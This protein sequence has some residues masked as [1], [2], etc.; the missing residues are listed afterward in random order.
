MRLCIKVDPVFEQSQ[1]ILSYTDTFTKSNEEIPQQ[2]KAI[3]SE[4]ELIEFFNSDYGYAHLQ[5]DINL[6]REYGGFSLGAGKVLDGRGHSITLIDEYA[7]ATVYEV[8]AGEYYFYSPEEATD[9]DRYGLFVNVNDGEIKNIKFIFSSSVSLVNDG[10][11]RE[12]A[13]SIVCGENNGLIHNCDLQ[14][15]GSFEYY[16]LS[17]DYEGSE[18]FK[19]DYGGFAG[20]NN[21]S[22]TNVG[23]KYE[24]FYLRLFTFAQ[25]GSMIG[26]MFIPAQTLAGGIIGE[27]TETANCENIKIQGRGVSYKLSG[28]G[29]DI[30]DSKTYAGAVAAIGQVDNVIVDFDVEYL[31][32][33]TGTEVISKNAVVH[34]GRAVNVTALNLYGGEENLRSNNMSSQ[35]DIEYCNYID[36]DNNVR[37]RV[38]LN[39]NNDQIIEVMPQRGTSGEMSF[40]KYKEENGKIA[41]DFEEYVNVPQNFMSQVI[42]GD[43]GMRVAA[44]QTDGKDYWE[45][46]VEETQEIQQPPA[47]EVKAFEE[48][49]EYISGDVASGEVSFVA[50]AIGGVVEYRIDGGE[51]IAY[52]GDII[53]VE[54]SQ[55]EFRAVSY[56][57]SLVSDIIVY[58][59]I[60]K[61]APMIV[62]EQWFNIVANK[63]YDGTDSV[64]SV[65]LNIEFFDTFQNFMLIKNNLGFSARYAQV[66]VGAVDII[67]DLW[68]KDSSKFEIAN[69]SLI[70]AGTITPKEVLVTLEKSYASYGLTEW[71]FN[72]T[73]ENLIGDDEIDLKFVTDANKYSTPSDSYRY[74]LAE[75]DYG[76]Y[77]VDNFA[78]L[79]SYVYGA[80]LE[81]GKYT[82]TQLLFDGELSSDNT[83][84]VGFADVN[85]ESAVHLLDVKYELIV[86]GIVKVKQCIDEVGLYRISV[87]MPLSLS[88]RYELGDE[89][90][91]IELQIDELPKGEAPDDAPDDGDGEE[92]ETPPDENEEGTDKKDKDDETDDLDYGVNNVDSLGSKGKT[93]AKAVGAAAVLAS[94]GI[95]VGV[96]VRKRKIVI[97]TKKK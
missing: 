85:D 69:N 53:I 11:A 28:R 63:V 6:H 88:D 41:E 80:E 56:D 2:S 68:V 92:V 27:M 75:K 18:I 45:L 46:K 61:R 34:I 17:Q 58:Q 72:Y 22:I 9:E 78:E 5:S 97:E 25:Q 13:T 54:N 73:V 89:I 95:G 70:I 55:I 4:Q 94:I 38:N 39:Y 31:D 67:I 30:D 90:E 1:D 43:I 84:K 93:V 16:Y 79:N 77:K 71:K 15:S 23:A 66:D 65:D 3:N 82:I 33:L 50:Q 60:I 44:Y 32:K 8:I 91:S 21:G 76:N 96:C 14:V 29:I 48:S 40:I 64:V 83:I 81:I 74:W 26:S 52:D 37:V 57:G 10:F 36:F 62:A 42:D 24:D 49:G 19:T 7:T 35:E 20:I 12:V 87:S 86:D 59:V 47:L 51:W